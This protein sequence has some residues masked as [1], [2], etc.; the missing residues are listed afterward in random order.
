MKN[1]ENALKNESHCDNNIIL[2]SKTDTNNKN[3]IKKGSFVLYQDYQ[4]IFE[5]LDNEQAGLLIKAI[6]AYT[7]NKE[8]K[9]NNY[10]SIVFIAIRQQLDRDALKYEQIVEQRRI[11]GSKGGKQRVTNQANAIFAKQV[12]A[13]Q[14]DNDN[15]NDNVNEINNNKDIRINN[16]FTKP[17]LEDIKSYCNERKNKVDA[18]HFFDY[19]SSNGWVVGKSKMKDWQATIR[20][21]ERN[22]EKS[23]TAHTKKEID[24]WNL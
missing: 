20:N 21:W 12:I 9:L 14:A 7:K 10:L 13:N 4:E 16:N 5:A 23:N 18:N 1:K 3:N 8:I 17:T 22:Q 24:G 19:Y 2:Q 11:A 15:D 6:F